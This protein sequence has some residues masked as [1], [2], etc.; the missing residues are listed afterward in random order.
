[1]NE[2]EHHFMCLLAICKS[3]LKKC[4]C[5][6]FAHFFIGLFVFPILSCMRCLHIWGIINS[7]GGSDG[8]LSAYNAVN[9]GSVLGSGGSPGE[10]NG[11]PLQYF[12]L[13]SPIDGGNWLTTVHGVA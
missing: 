9:L 7:P 3:P 6:S 5:S 2:V 1:M 8:K 12:C 13:V 11:N 4:L 10:G